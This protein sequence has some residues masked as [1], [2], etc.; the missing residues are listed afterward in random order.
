MYKYFKHDKHPFLSSLNSKVDLA[1]EAGAATSEGSGFATLA[2]T[3]LAITKYSRME[4]EPAE[5]S[6]SPQLSRCSRVWT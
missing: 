2:A 1:V 5:V 6:P 4:D 3:V